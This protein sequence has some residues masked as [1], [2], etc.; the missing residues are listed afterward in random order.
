MIFIAVIIITLMSYFHYN[1]LP[2]YDINLAGKFILNEQIN[3]DFDEISQILGFNPTDKLLIIHAD[4]LGLCESVNSATFESFKNRAI[5]SASVMM[6]TDEINEVASFSNTNQNYDMGIHL[7]VT[8]EWKL[9]K[10]GGI[11]NNE[12]IPS[13]LNKKNH[14]Y[15]NKRKFTKNGKLD[16][17]RKEL[18]AQI[19]LGKSMGINPSH[20]DSHEG[21][22][23]FDPDIFKLYL[24]LAK[25]ND[26]LAFVPI[27]ASVH[28]DENFKKPKHAIIIDQFHMLPEG[29]NVS[30]IKDY[31]FNVI[32]NLQPGLSQIIVH[33][34]KDEEELRE[35]TI[36]HP[37]FDY[38]WR[39]LDFDVF[40]SIDFKDHLKKHNIKIINWKDLKKLI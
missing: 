2:I 32:K 28:F 15:W 14:L 6:T 18:Q 22:L 31:Y 8:S 16:E 29:I 26:L 38:R 40:N 25:E 10:W 7:T 39:Q 4:D 17:I 12:D 27:Q 24:D 34:G 3:N 9:H 19:D 13:I 36:D 23:F 1:Q 20:I 11:L 5:S 35:I 33:L 37:N 21:A 30:E